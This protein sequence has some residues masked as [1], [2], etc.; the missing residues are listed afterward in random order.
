[1]RFTQD[2]SGLLE[3]EATVSE[4]GQKTSGVFERG[5]A[6]SSPEQREAALRTLQRLKVRARD[7][8]PDRYL[9]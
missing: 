5:R 6:F 4:T 2:Q 3:V 7:L 8:L 1:M 9:L